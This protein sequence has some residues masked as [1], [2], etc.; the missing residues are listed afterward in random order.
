MTDGVGNFGDVSENDQAIVSLRASHRV[1]DL[2]EANMAIQGEANSVAGSLD[3]LH[4][5]NGSPNDGPA[6]GTLSFA[7][8]KRRE[9][10]YLP[11]GLN[12]QALR[13]WLP[14]AR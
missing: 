3:V 14:R 2:S 10:A 4:K 8:K 7:V 6:S 1:P 5:S 11:S 9:N 13:L 12:A